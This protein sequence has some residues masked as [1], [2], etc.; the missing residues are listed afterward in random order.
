MLLKEILKELN[1]SNKKSFYRNGN[2]TKYTLTYDYKPFIEQWNN[3]YDKMNKKTISKLED[4]KDPYKF[5]CDINKIMFAAI[6][7]ISSKSYSCKYIN[8]NENLVYNTANDILKNSFNSGFLNK[9]K[10]PYIFLIERNNWEKE[11]WLFGIK[12]TKANINDIVLLKEKLTDFFP[13]K[14]FTIGYEIK[15]LKDIDL[16]INTG[17]FNKYN[18]IDK[19]INFKSLLKLDKSKLENKLYKGGLLR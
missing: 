4:Y 1:L 5:I 17:Y 19:K 10:E 14:Q 7:K 13:N 18:I 9:F 2:H 11:T 8:N 12:I 15:D 6:P 3:I 16:N